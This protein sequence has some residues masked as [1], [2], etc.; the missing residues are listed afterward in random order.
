MPSAA[1]S[2]D[3]TLHDVRRR[4]LRQARA[5]FFAQGYSSFTMDALA[6]ELGM[7]KCALR[8]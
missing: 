1:P 4:I 3:P 8:R 7:S 2:T 5:D 6:G